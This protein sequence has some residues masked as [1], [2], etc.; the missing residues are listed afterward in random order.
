[1]T[2]VV[3]SPTP[4][5]PPPTLRLQLRLQLQLRQPAPHRLVK[6]LRRMVDQTPS[7]L[8][9][10]PWE[11]FWLLL[12]SAP[13]SSFTSNVRER[14]K[15]PTREAHTHT[16]ESVAPERCL[17]I[18][19]N[20]DQSTAP[21]TTN[22]YRIS[23]H[24][25]MPLRARTA[26]DTPERIFRTRTSVLHLVL[27]P[28]LRLGDQKHRKLAPSGSLD[29]SYI[30][31]WRTPYQKMPIRK[32]LN[33]HQR[34]PNEG[35]H[36]PWRDL[37]SIKATNHHRHHHHPSDCHPKSLRSFFY[38]SFVSFVLCV[39]N[40][41]PLGLLVK[42]SLGGSWVHAFLEVPR[43]VRTLVFFVGFST[44]P[45]CFQLL[46]V[47]HEVLVLNLTSTPY[48]GLYSSDFSTLPHSPSGPLP[49]LC[50][51]ATL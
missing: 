9:W 17:W 31:M 28:H 24:S 50:A 46:V 51:L 14:E 3:S 33:S 36:H 5:P 7:P 19:R 29:S 49:L 40:R 8:L 43:S 26:C 25:H 27:G 30:P 20:H 42:A 18:S 11:V 2:A 12:S 37:R 32:S 35:K 21:T 23:H 34:T 44:C 10:G 15:A 45:L 6:M 39:R 13:L 16:E 4:L 48:F 41:A 38:L 22:L 47:Q 1:M